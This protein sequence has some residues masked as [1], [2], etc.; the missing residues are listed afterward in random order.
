LKP[1]DIPPEVW[2]FLV[3]RWAMHMKP[4]GHKFVEAGLAGKKFTD[5]APDMPLGKLNYTITEDGSWKFD[6]ESKEDTGDT[7]IAY[8]DFE[9]GYRAAA[10]INYDY[11]KAVEEGKF[12]IEGSF[13]DAMKVGLMMSDIVKAFAK[14]IRDAEKKFSVELP[15]Y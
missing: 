9:N 10:D 12:K 7:V 4:V 3:E 2:R 13:E 6:F 11:V 15:K 14:A 8:A 5:K 1:A